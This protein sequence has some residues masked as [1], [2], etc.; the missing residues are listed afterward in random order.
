M[1]SKV[2]SN[3]VQIICRF[4]KYEIKLHLSI[5]FPALQMQMHCVCWSNQ[6]SIKNL[7]TPSREFNSS[8]TLF[9]GKMWV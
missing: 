3:R 6:S 7:S 4:S 5:A 2:T 1:K 8:Q 9:Q